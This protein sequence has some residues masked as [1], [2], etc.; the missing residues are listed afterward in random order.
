[1]IAIVNARTL[2]S[3]LVVAALGCGG[4]PDPAAPPSVAAT[5]PASSVAPVA[6]EYDRA[7]A[8]RAISAVD[9]SPCFDKPP[10]LDAQLHVTL[11]LHPS[12][13]VEPSADRPYEGTEA[14][15]CAVALY[16]NVRIPG[17][18]GVPKEMG[19]TVPHRRP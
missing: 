18:I 1:M 16:K 3:C 19:R 8:A 7:A 2:P 14:G 6:A 15:N 11:T 17:W 4:S 5:P 10:L 9:T 13:R 12:G